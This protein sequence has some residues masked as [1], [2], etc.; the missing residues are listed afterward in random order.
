MPTEQSSAG[1]APEAGHFRRCW[2]CIALVVVVVTGIRAREQS[3]AKLREWTDDQAVPTVAVDQPGRQGHATRPSTCRAGW[4]PIRARRSLRA[5][6]GYLKSWSADIG[7]PVKAGQ[8][9]AEIEAPDLDQQMLQARADLASQQAN[10]Q[11][12]GSDADA[13]ARRWSRRTSSRSRSSTSAPPTSPTRR[14]RSSPARPMSSGWKRLRVQEHHRA[15]RRHRHRARHRRR[16]ADQRRRRLGARAV[17][18][19]GHHASCAS[20]STCRRITCRRSGS[21][22]RP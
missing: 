11:A 14:W 22:P 3:G 21:A 12:V 1:F 13:G 17:R 9:L 4:K 5:S 16:R 6:S 8:V 20:T 18:G 15:V 10:A 2:Q 7:A 19:L